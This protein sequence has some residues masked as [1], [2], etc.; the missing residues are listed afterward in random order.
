MTHAPTPPQTP[1]TNQWPIGF[2]KL[3]PEGRC[4]PWRF[5]PH[6]SASLSVTFGAPLPEAL[7]CATLGLGSSVRRSWRDDGG[8]GGGG[9]R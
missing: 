4:V 3:M 6:P 8:E 2:D 9:V 7:G 5:F 1:F